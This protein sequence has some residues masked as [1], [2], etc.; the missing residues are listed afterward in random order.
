MQSDVA[1]HHNT[2]GLPSDNLKSVAYL[3]LS[4]KNLIEFCVKTPKLKFVNVYK[5]LEFYTCKEA[6]VAYFQVV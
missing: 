5:F 4:T 2:V 1:L 6:V 3:S